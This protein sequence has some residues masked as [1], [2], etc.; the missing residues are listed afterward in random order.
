MMIAMVRLLLAIFLSPLRSMARREAVNAA[1]RHQV[2]I[3]RRQARGRIK[4]TS[5]DRLQS[6]GLADLGTDG[7]WRTGVRLGPRLG[8]V[9]AQ[10]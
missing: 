8:R 1:L 7:Q 6:R 2:V 5:G 10:P 4:L 9:P 3:L